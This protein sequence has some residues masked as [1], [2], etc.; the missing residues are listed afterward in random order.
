MG[1]QLA[2][3]HDAG[4]AAAQGVEHQQRPLV[5][6]AADDPAD[7]TREI[8]GIDFLLFHLPFLFYI[9]KVVNKNRKE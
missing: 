4:L 3:A 2:E 6:E 8:F 1:A 5:S 9:T 7:G